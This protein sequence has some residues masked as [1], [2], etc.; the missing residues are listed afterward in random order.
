ML[1]KDE[2]IKSLKNDKCPSVAYSKDD[3]PAKITK[4]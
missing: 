1:N 3:T 2:D 4:K